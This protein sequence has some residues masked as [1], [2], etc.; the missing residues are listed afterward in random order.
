[1]QQSRPRVRY[2]VAFRTGPGP[3]LIGTLNLDG[4]SLVL[5]GRSGEEIIE[6]R[7]PYLAVAEVRIGRSNEEAMNG[8]PTVMLACRDASPVQIEPLAAGLLHELAD[9][10]AELATEHADPGEQVVVTVPLRRD[11]V[12]RAKE[13]VAQGPPF[14]PAVLG[15]RRHEVF[16]TERAAIFVFT[17]PHVRSRLDRATRNPTLWFAGLAWSACVAGRP[18]LSS[19]PLPEHDAE[20]VYRWVAAG[21]PA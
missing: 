10:L 11:C 17:G 2:P 21:E 16:V 6:L 12:A 20:P 7:V 5:R 13:L 14:N 15:L 8:R 1:M 9:L 4:T 19:D 3:P 18:R